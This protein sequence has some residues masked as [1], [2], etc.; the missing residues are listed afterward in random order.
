MWRRLILAGPTILLRATADL[1]ALLPPFDRISIGFPGVICCGRVVTA[2]HFDMAAWRDYPLQAAVSRRFGTP[3]RLLNDAEVQGLGVVAGRG[4]EVVLTLGT[5]VGSAVFSNG[6][7]HRT[8]SWRST[9]S[10]KARPT[11]TISATRPASPTASRNGTAA[12]S[13]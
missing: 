7:L 1:T 12:S 8:S 6:R 5:G 13:I 3:A 2:P 10:T 9:R 11:T 4:L